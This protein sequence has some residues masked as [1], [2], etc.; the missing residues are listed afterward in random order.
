MTQ[1]TRTRMHLLIVL[2]GIVVAL[3]VCTAFAVIYGSYRWRTDTE[4]LRARLEAGRLPIKPAI[5]DAR[6][7]ESLPAPVQRYF[8]IALKDGQPII[9]AIKVAHAGQFSL[10][11]TE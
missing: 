5:Y 9:A 4:K 7:L 11:E 3:I 8:R 1:M 6:E 2:G 10:G